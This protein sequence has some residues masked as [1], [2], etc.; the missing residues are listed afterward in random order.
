MGVNLIPYPLSALH[1]YHPLF[2]RPYS[3]QLI[4]LAL[5]TS[6]FFVPEG[7]CV[8]AGEGS[9]VLELRSLSNKYSFQPL[10]KLL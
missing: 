8:P 2:W 5:D 4:N 7:V 6:T 3:N 10:G 1:D 9:L